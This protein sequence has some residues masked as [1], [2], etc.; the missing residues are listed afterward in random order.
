MSDD[1]EQGAGAVG[2]EELNH[3]MRARRE[4]LAALEKASKVGA[5]DLPGFTADAAY[6]S[7]LIDTGKTDEAL[8]LYREMATRHE[9][10][11]AERSLILLAEAQIVAGRQ[12][13]AKTVIAEFRQ[14]FPTSARAAEV[15]ALELRAGSAG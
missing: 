6:A 9:G 13:D 11:F 10:F 1:R 2:G 7:A 12:A 15:A 5:K 8:Q 4:K 3:V 14:R